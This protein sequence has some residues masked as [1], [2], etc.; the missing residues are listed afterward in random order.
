VNDPDVIVTAPGAEPVR[1]PWAEFVRWHE[2]V[3]GPSCARDILREGQ[4]VV[5]PDGTRLHAVKENGR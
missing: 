4:D 3:R 5:R 1:M 2:D